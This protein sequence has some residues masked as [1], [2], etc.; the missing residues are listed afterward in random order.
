MEKRYE[1]M[2]DK[3]ENSIPGISV[4]NSVSSVGEL[5][6]NSN[7]IMK[8]RKLLDDNG[9]NDEKIFKVIGEGL[10]ATR[11]TID[12][13]CDEHIEVDHETRRK[14]AL[15]ALELKE[16][17]KRQSSVEVNNNFTFAQMVEVASKARPVE[18]VND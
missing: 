1:K 13:F 5:E 12:K 15:I 2:L 6:V 9:A 10:G 8:I 18:V 17:I 4:D 3:I 14:F 11:M 16:Y 7:L